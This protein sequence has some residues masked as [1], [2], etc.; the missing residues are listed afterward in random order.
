MSL[1]ERQEDSFPVVI[2]PNS[3][4]VPLNLNELW[5]YRELLYFLTWRDIKVRYKQTVLGMAWAVLQPFL[6]MLVFTVFF[7]QLVKVPSDGFPYPIFVY[8]ALLPW[9]L[10][11]RA[12]TDASTSL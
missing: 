1:S 12:L 9:Q 2:K 7:G 5:E 11:S 10:F 8:T 6:M 4:I 3:G